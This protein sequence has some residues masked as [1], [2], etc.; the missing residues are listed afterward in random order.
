MKFP[1]LPPR[2]TLLAVCAAALAFSAGYAR[3][4]PFA[5]ASYPL[6]RWFVPE[7]LCVHSGWHWAPARSRAQRRRAEYFLAGRAWIKSWDVPDSIAGGSGEGGWNATGGGYGGGLQFTLGTWNR[8][9]SLSGG[10]V[11]YA[12]SES[13]I[14]AQPP[15]EQMYAALM[16]VRQD[17]GSWSEW[18]NTS[19]ACGL[20]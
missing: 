17:G 12:A 5:R 10:R 4:L 7:A 13:G 3:G 6:P 14:A 16:I 8:A 2:L 18:P 20:R 15:A 19:R 11:S 9:A 1:T